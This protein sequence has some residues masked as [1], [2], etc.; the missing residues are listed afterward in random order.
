MNL[1]IRDV[2]QAEPNVGR[3]ELGPNF[4]NRTGPAWRAGPINI[5]I[6]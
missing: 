2:N 4:L 3:A 1:Y 5:L 6:R